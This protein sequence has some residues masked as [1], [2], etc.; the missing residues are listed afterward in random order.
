MTIFDIV[1]HDKRKTKTTG[2][3]GTLI[4]RLSCNAKKNSIL[5]LNYCL[6]YNQ[7][8][9]APVLKKKTFYFDFIT[10][11]MEEIRSHIQVKVYDSRFPPSI[12][13]NIRK[14]S[15]KVTL[16]PASDWRKTMQKLWRYRIIGIF[17]F[18]VKYLRKFL[19]ARSMTIWEPYTRF[20]EYP[21]T[22]HI[23]RIFFHVHKT[24]AMGR[25]SWRG[26]SFRKTFDEL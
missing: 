21:K 15:I 9:L 10:A 18:S 4:F 16:T 5:I 23:F 19:T 22:F 1:T 3:N 2:C 11:K 6:C 26:K 24:M 17:P 8:T 20:F 13:K 7:V 14:N 12:F 25:W